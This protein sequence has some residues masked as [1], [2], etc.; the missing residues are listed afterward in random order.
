MPTLIKNDAIA[1]NDWQLI[2]DKESQYSDLP[3]GQV[4]VPLKLWQGYKTELAARGDFG[5]WLDSDEPAE[6][7]GDVVSS[8]PLIAINFPVFSDGRGYSYARNLRSRFNYTGEL[9]AIGDVLLDQL[10]YLKQVGFDSFALRDDQNAE[11][12]GQKLQSFKYSYQSTVD[13]PTPV[14]QSR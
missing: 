4:I 9:R 13:R 3:Q 7:L 2:S 11:Q 14:F 8:L 5:V 1:T 12:I 6:A 10:F